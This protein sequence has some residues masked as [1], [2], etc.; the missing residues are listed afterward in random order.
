M[1]NGID[2]QDVHGHPHG[3]FDSRG[4]PVVL[5]PAPFVRPIDKVMIGLWILL[6]GSQ[7]VTVLYL[8]FHHGGH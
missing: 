8:V 4:N 5:T 3:L 2:A 1:E 7:A 6:G